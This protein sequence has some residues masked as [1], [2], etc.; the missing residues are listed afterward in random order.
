M[1]K[2]IE[3]LYRDDLGTVCLKT[4]TKQKIIIRNKNEKLNPEIE[5]K[6]T[7]PKENI[8]FRNGFRY[9]KSLLYENLIKPEKIKELNI[10]LQSFRYFINE[11]LI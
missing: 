7:K 4:T 5:L 8:K 1:L 6:I 3:G 9:K 11:G 10:I 2:N